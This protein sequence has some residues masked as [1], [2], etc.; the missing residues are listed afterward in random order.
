MA[1]SISC[2]F[3]GG[4]WDLRSWRTRFLT[5]L[6]KVSYI[7]LGIGAYLRSIDAALELLGELVRGSG[8]LWAC[9]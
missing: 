6:I 2:H 5:E 9:S 4:F 8:G 1:C 7:P 3:L